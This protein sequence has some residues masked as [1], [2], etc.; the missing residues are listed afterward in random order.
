MEIVFSIVI[1]IFSVI[2]H[3]VAHGAVAYSLGDNTAKY[4]GRLTL[5]PLKHLDPVGSVLVPVLLVIMS[6]ISGG[7]IIFGW[8]KPVPINPF[9]FKDKKWGSMKVA[10]A[11]PLS[12]LSLAL[13]FGL[14]LR[15]VPAAV[16]PFGVGLMFSYIVYINI[17]L[18]IFNLMPIPPL[19]GSHVLFSLLP[20]GFEK[21][22]VFL[23]QYGFIILLFVLFFLFNWVIY[24][25]NFIFTLITGFS[26]F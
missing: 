8:A 1:L 12:N 22:K 7:G 18:A 4:A 20:R 21:T 23:Y 10:L 15:F 24:I 9:N 25:I 17:L 26:L 5:N 6:Q 2:I 16:I 11:G 14:I 3:E 13:I 19:D